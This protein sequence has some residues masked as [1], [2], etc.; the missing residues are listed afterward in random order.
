VCTAGPSHASLLVDLHDSNVAITSFS[1]SVVANTITT[2]E[3]WSGPGM[4]V[5]EIIL[6]ALDTGDPFTL[7]RNITIEGDDWSEFVNELLDPAGQLNDDS[8][9]FPQPDG[10]PAGFTTSNDSDGIGFD[11]AT[12]TPD[13]GG[14]FALASLTT[15]TRDVLSFSGGSG[16]S[17]SVQI[18][19]AFIDTRGPFV[20]GDAFATGTNDSLLVSSEAVP[21]PEASAMFWLA[22]LLVGAA[23][24]RRG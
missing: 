3:T 5:I 9:L 15:G 7:V 4:G 6:E 2:T 12:A 18:T 21:L 13:S 17:A 16:A 8:D 11:L 20:P 24:A 23:F 22:M 1:S 14:A 19:Y 10:I